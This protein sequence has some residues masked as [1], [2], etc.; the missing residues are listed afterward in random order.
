MR[1][2]WYRIIGI[3]ILI[4]GF[5]CPSM[6]V[7]AE[8][9][10]SLTINYHATSASTTIDGATFHVVMVASR[11]ASGNSYTLVDPYRDVAVDPNHVIPDGSTDVTADVRTAAKLFVD[12]DTTAGM[13]VTTGSDGRVTESIETAGLYLIWQTGSTGTASQYYKASPMLVYIPTVN[14]DGATWQDHIT[15][16]PKTSKR[17]T[18]GGGDS[19]GGGG[20]DGGDGGD[21]SSGGA[22]TIPVKKPDKVKE[23]EKLPETELEEMEGTEGSD[24]SDGSGGAG[25]DEP[26]YGLLD[27]YG[28][29]MAGFI[30]NGGFSGDTSKIRVYGAIAIFALI[31]LAGL[32]LRRYMKRH[33]E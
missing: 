27:G 29:F 32:G 12:V 23:P 14:D 10:Y 26:G 19:G 8:S 3:W 31:A 20:D 21:D 15:I 22:S 2:T 11:D 4:L 25:N 6:P 7:C 13:A 33:E 9:P 17:D 28:D 16:E 1:Q 30:S 18:G 24:G 5:L